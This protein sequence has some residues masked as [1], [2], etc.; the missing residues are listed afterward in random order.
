MKTRLIL[1]GLVVMLSAAFTTANAQLDEPAVKVLPSSEKGIVKVLYAIDSDKAVE[2]KFLSENGLITSD[3]IKAGSFKN[4]FSKKYDISRIKA[5]SF[6]VEVSS[7][8]LTVRYK[9]IE[10]KERKAFI[11]Y[12]E[13]TTYNH[14]LVATIN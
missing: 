1:S 14:P 8:D 11:P 13:K 6:W 12:L 5:K 2:V 7:A 9:M 3:K 4:G 10:S